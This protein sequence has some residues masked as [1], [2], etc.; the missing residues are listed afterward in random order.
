MEVKDLHNENYKILLK[1]IKVDIN[2]NT[3]H[4]HRLEDLALLTL[5]IPPKATYSQNL[6]GILYR[7]RNTHPKIHIESQGTQDSQN[8]HEK[9]GNKDGRL[10]YLDL[11]VY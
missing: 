2:G 7:S 5:S 4:V 3:S 8:H 6:N 11:K 10:T 1:E 9:K